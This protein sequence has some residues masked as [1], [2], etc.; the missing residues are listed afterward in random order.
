MQY[1]QN[2]QPPETCYSA[3]LASG[4]A[5]M[6]QLSGSS[7]AAPA[8]SVGDSAAQGFV[9]SSTSMPWPRQVGLATAP[10]SQQPRGQQ[11][12]TTAFPGLLCSALMT[13]TG[14]GSV[15]T[16]VLAQKPPQYHGSGYA[17]SGH[18]SEGST[19]HAMLGYGMA[20]IGD[21]I[22]KAFL[23]RDSGVPTPAWAGSSRSA[24]SLVGMQATPSPMTG[25]S[26]SQVRAGS[27]VVAQRCWWSTR[28]SRR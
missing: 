28:G 3:V 22:G 9:G 17:P 2:G 7:P 23:G 5:W 25:R 6:P 11:E 18:D 1:P 12:G 15:S 14:L 8:G 26:E 10:G 24:Q 27:P 4:P 20:A 19:R 16:P 13:G 21:F